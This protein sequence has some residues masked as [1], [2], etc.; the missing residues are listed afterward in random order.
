MEDMKLQTLNDMCMTRKVSL[1][2]Q[3]EFG[4]AKQ[5]TSITIVNNTINLS[6]YLWI[7]LSWDPT[8]RGGN[9]ALK[10]AFNQR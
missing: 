5:L 1:L 7:Y 2:H 4:I 6:K 9:F 8:C 3:I 10:D